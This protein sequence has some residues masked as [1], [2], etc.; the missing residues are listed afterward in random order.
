MRRWG[1]VGRGIGRA[2]PTAA[3]L[4]ASTATLSNSIPYT[5]THR[6]AHHPAEPGLSPAAAHRRR[7]DPRAR[8]ARQRVARLRQLVSQIDDL[9]GEIRAMSRSL[10]TGRTNIA[11]FADLS[12]AELVAEIGDISRF[13]TRSHF[14][15][16]YG[17][18]PTGQLRTDRQVPP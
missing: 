9:T 2:R 11:G 18:A 7:P 8:I 6:T 10:E 15:M 17:T 1:S 12:A 3:L 4:A 16:A 14:A 13:R 5:S